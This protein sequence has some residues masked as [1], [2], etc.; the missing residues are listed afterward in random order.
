MGATAELL[1]IVLREFADTFAYEFD[2][3]GKLYTNDDRCLF[4]LF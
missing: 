1:L 3:L 2:V 4:A